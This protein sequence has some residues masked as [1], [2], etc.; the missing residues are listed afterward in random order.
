MVNRAALVLKYKEPAIRWINEADPDPEGIHISLD[1][2]NRERTVYLVS[3]EDA[4]TDTA[5]R[6]WVQDNL[7]M[8]WES[9]LEGWYTDEALWPTDRTLKKFDQWFDIECHTV[10]VDTVDGPLFDDET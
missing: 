6:R 3:D 5:V 2:V 10:L 1:D 7:D 4:D 8:L 9:E